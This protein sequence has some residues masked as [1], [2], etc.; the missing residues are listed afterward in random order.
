MAVM[1]TDD[2]IS[3]ENASPRS[4]QRWSI[5]LA[6]GEG[7]RMSPFIKTWL[8]HSRPKQ[9]CTFM[10][11][12]SMLHHTVDRAS[13][14]TGNSRLVTIIGQ[15]HRQFV[16]SQRRAGGWGHIIEQPCNR[17]TA[18]GVFMPAAHIMQRD[19][20]ATIVIFPS[21]HFVY[22]EDRF[23]THIDEACNLAES[24]NNSIVLIGALPNQAERE[25]GWIESA[26]PLPNWSA[27]PSH[28][29]PLRV[30]RFREKPPTHEANR[31]YRRR[32]LWNTMVV[33]VRVKTLWSL[34]WRCLP[35][36]M[37][38]LE[39]FQAMQYNAEQGHL[40]TSH[41]ARA[42][43]QAYR[44]L[45]YAGDFSRDILQP[46]AHRTIVLPLVDVTWNDWGQPARVH[47]TIAA[48]GMA[49]AY[50]PSCLGR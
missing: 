50:P 24:F 33:A 26:G 16:D 1:K 45:E 44:D 35:D 4:G 10:G 17:G 18:M 47:E 25:Y 14:V 20:E 11:S 6:G 22:P 28:G 19:P 31:L 39:A 15:G 32:A 30:K 5:I 9:Y 42:I 21:D 36:M 40:K 37:Q 41:E 7:V 48:Y 3:Q 38:Q 49:P 12:R 46:S 29:A 23:L 27:R 2:R 8:G 34:G 43:Q 13:A